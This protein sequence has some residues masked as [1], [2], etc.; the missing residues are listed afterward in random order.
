MKEFLDGVNA[1]NAK[2]II[3]NESKVLCAR[4]SYSFNALIDMKL[5]PG[6]V[7]IHSASEPYNEAQE[8]SQER[9]NA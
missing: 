7:Y 9:I 8:I 4:G 6:A 5:E 2:E 3:K 1:W